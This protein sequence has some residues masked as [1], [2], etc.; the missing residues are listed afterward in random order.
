MF[1]AYEAVDELIDDINDDY[2]EACVDAYEQIYEEL[3]ERVECG[4]MSLA[5]A[6]IVNEAA[7]EKYLGDND[8]DDPTFEYAVDICLESLSYTDPELFEES[9]SDHPYEGLMS[10]K[11]YQKM[12]KAAVM[13]EDYQIPDKYAGNK[14]F[15]R[16]FKKDVAKARKSAD[17]A[18]KSGVKKSVAA[19]AAAAAVIGLATGVA[20]YDKKTGNVSAAAS[21]AKGRVTGHAKDK[22]YQKL[23]GS[24]VLA[25]RNNRNTNRI[26]DKAI[27][28]RNRAN[29]ADAIEAFSSKAMG[30]KI[31]RL[32]RHDATKKRIKANLNK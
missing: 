4:E 13:D 10:Q 29:R 22:G 26:A 11:A 15:V 3:I 28:D 23:S 9:S 8:D 19:A 20:A 31:A 24:D 14:A 18:Q 1:D 32:D 2:Y 5:E 7:A 12:V 21:N 27:K 25:Q 30:D 17:T 16:A 6:E